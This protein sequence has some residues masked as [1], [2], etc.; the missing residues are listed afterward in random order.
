MWHTCIYLQSVCVC[1]WERERETDR[2]TDRQ[3]QREGGGRREK[4]RSLINLNNEVLLWTSNVNAHYHSRGRSLLKGSS[5]ATLLCA[6]TLLF[7]PIMLNG[8]GSQKTRDYSSFHVETSQLALD[9]QTASSVFYVPISRRTLCKPIN[10]R[11]LS[12]WLYENN[13]SSSK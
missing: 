1:V 11:D 8:E 12:N 9:K 6:N 10:S 13:N 5:N 2:Q 3:G 4:E 7:T